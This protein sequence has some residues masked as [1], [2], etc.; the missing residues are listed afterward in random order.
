MPI[1]YTSAKRRGRS[2]ALSIVLGVIPHTMPLA[3]DVAPTPAPSPDTHDLTGLAQLFT[4]Y[5]TMP[6]VI[7]DG[8]QID[9]AIKNGPTDSVGVTAETVIPKLIH[10]KTGLYP[11]DNIVQSIHN[12]YYA[13]YP[14]ALFNRPDHGNEN[15][16]K[17][18]VNMC[19]IFAD[20]L[21][22]PDKDTLTTLSNIDIEQFTST[23]PGIDPTAI[24]IPPAIAE[25][26]IKLHEGFHCADS[27]YTKQLQD[28]DDI[29]EDSFVDYTK[30][31][32]RR[33]QENVI[34]Q[35]AEI[36]ADVAAALKMAQEGF[37]AY[38]PDYA[39]SRAMAQTFNRASR[40][41]DLDTAKN[42]LF[43]QTEIWP[44]RETGWPDN[45]TYVP[46]PILTHN[47]VKGLL[48]V[49]DFVAAMPGDVLRAMTMDDIIETAY[50]ITE[51]V[52]PDAET[53]RALSFQMW[54]QARMELGETTAPAFYDTLCPSPCA[55]AIT[56]SQRILARRALDDYMHTLNRALASYKRPTS[57]QHVI[58]PRITAGMAV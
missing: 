35:K 47:T 50:H 5:A 45:I 56:Q 57:P 4:R 23:I 19:V 29:Y 10:N 11:N 25:R 30:N 49:N 7:L 44:S 17:P 18:P 1:S 53:L 51:R 43:N 24:H 28:I 16:E 13:R 37:G 22:A 46:V 2:L 3:H 39:A 31:Q 42:V 34:H 15:S 40:V 26:F 14:L 38:L 33:L 36:F 32:E 8:H 20:L 12:S 52:A 27:V 9:R 21:S 55:T 41:D 48:M 58:K 54:E 6:V